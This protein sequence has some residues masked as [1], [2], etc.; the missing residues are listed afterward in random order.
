[1]NEEL[2]V[3]KAYEI[4]KQAEKIVTLPTLGWNVRIRKVGN[5]E[6][7]M[8]GAKDLVTSYLAKEDAEAIKEKLAKD[9]T[10]EQRVDNAEVSYEFSQV[11]VMAGM[12]EPRPVRG[13]WDEKD[14]T[15]EIHISL[16]DVDIM[17][18]ASQILDFSGLTH[19]ATEE[20]TDFFR[21][22]VGGSDSSDGGDVRTTAHDDLE[23][24]TEGVRPELSDLQTGD[25]AE[26]PGD[27][28]KGSTTTI[29]NGSA[30]ISIP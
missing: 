15:E 14:N 2:K 16:L 1:M 17:W 18:L 11:L 5:L 13:D 28:K 22:R 21:D 8:S 4:N 19:G 24:A 3:T 29:G 23:S 7:V 27:E 25:E 9:I 26:S 20:L 30:S 10:P 6:L 12:V